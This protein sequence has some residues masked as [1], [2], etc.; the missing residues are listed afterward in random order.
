MRTAAVNDLN[1]SI[2]TENGSGSASANS[3]LFKS[4][5]KMGIPCSSKNL[6]PSNIQGLPT[7]YLI[8]A[9][10]EGY[11]CR[12]GVLDAMVAFNP[13][14]IAGDIEQVRPEGLVLY[15]DS[16]PLPQQFIRDSLTYI[17]VPATQL[18]HDH[19]KSPQ[20]RAKQRNM[21]YVGALAQL[22][23]IPLELVDQSL[24]D[25][26]GDK[27][28][29]IEPNKLCIEL[30][31]RHLEDAG[32]AQDV[33]WLEAI[34]GGNDAK[35]MTEG[36]NAAAL[37]AIFGGATVVTWYP[38]TPSSSLVESMI[39]QIG[40]YR[41]DESGRARYTIL[42]A[43]D[44]LASI[45]MAVGAGWAG[46]RSMTSTAGPGLSLMQEGIGLAYVTEVPCVIF[47]V[48]RAGPSTGLPTRTQQSD[49]SVMH[50]GSHGDT[51][52]I[53]LI[54]HD[55]LSAF[56][57]G[58]RAFDFADRYQTPVFV[59]MDL[60][61]G[62]NL[63]ISDPLKMP[64]TPI[65]RGKVLHK[66]DLDRLN[67]SFQRYLD[68]DGD[69]I[70]YRTLPGEDHPAAAYFARGSGHD[71]NAVYS[72]D[73][74]VYRNLLDRLRR[75]Y[76][77]ARTDVPAPLI[78]NSTGSA[79]GVISFGT[80]YEPAREA[81]DRLAAQDVHTDHLLIQALP[82]SPEIEEFV[83]K[84]ETVFVVEQNRDGQMTQILRDDFPQYAARYRPIL[85]YD[86]LPPAPKDIVNKILE[87]RT[88]S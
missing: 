73:P 54:P 66:E 56:E 29:V 7:W 87:V 63:S 58:W 31:Y 6:F 2:A 65:D 86:G 68:V 10:K 52:H 24:K 17:G 80:S 22:F 15:D 13:A 33:G 47:N 5:F 8:R 41:T 60:D 75:K 21:V 36:N 42:Q 43:E 67:G 83:A 9:S 79:I 26:F 27:P 51:K 20:L 45:T 78:E 32:A 72:E 19:I 12:K 62:M 53:V 18:V 85:L 77:N 69:G 35:I 25:T 76:E 64:D 50:Q 84:H 44:E 74:E 49:I 57:M 34:P 81:R 28:A 30:G 88:A 11:L 82:L 40:K 59:M 71:T 61:L 16:Q 48:G 55:N 14:T 39:A 37:G 38:I 46:A 4:I 23:G 70:P 1:I 3:I